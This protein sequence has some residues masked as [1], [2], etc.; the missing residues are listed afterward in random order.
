[1]LSLPF[2]N[3]YGS[4]GVSPSALRDKICLTPTKFPD[5]GTASLPCSPS[6][7]S[8]DSGSDGVS[9]S[10]LRDKTSR[11]TKLP[12]GG[13]PSLPEPPLSLILTLFNS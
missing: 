7:S 10:S 3:A 4:D 11:P 2:G 6:P 9:P 8:D 5:G 1:M 13:T 12:D